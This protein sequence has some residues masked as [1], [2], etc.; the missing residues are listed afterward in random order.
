MSSSYAQKSVRATRAAA[1]GRSGERERIETQRQRQR[2]RRREARSREDESQLFKS[3]GLTDCRYGME[4]KACTHYCS[5]MTTSRLVH[6][7]RTRRDALTS[8]HCTSLYF[9]SLQISN[10]LYHRALLEHCRLCS[11][12][13]RVEYTAQLDYSECQCRKNLC[14]LLLCSALLCSLIFVSLCSC[15]SMKCSATRGNGN[16]QSEC[17]KHTNECTPVNQSVCVYLSVK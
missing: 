5:D 8:L 17:R 9:T 3:T 14:S 7:E 15:S 12:H 10:Y 2:T 4:W 1:A 6:N 11:V 13:S 16:G